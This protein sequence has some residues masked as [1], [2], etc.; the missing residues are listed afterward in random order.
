LEEAFNGCPGEGTERDPHCCRLVRTRSSKALVG[1][2][3]LVD[4]RASGAA[5][6]VVVPTDNVALQLDSKRLPF[7]LDFDGNFHVAP[8]F[9]R[10]VRFD[11]LH[12]LARMTVL[13]AL[14]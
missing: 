5:A 12:G 8:A 11:H 10:L 1:H 6:V 9:A 2:P 4:A 7:M 13:R 14:P 3:L